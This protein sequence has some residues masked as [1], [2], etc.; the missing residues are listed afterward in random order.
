MAYGYGITLAEAEAVANAALAEG[1]RQGFPPLGVAVLDPGGHPVVVKRDD[2]ATFF[3]ITVAWGKAWGALAMG[4]SSRGL[5]ERLGDRPLFLQAL[6]DLA[7]GRMVPVA[8]GLLIW[9]QGQL[10]GAVGVSGATS[11]QDEDAARAGIA[12]AGLSAEP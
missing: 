9:R 8:G 10:V 5:G 4:V 7:G 12:A 1:R 6:S 2:G 11:D 3:R